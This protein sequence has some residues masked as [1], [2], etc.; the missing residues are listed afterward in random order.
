MKHRPVFIVISICVVALSAALCLHRWQ[1]P[2]GQKIGALQ[3]VT[4]ALRHYAIDHGGWFPTNSEAPLHALQAIYPSYIEQPGYLAGLSGDVQETTK[5][6]K[7]GR[8]LNPM[9]SS[10]VYW[11]GFKEDDCSDA[12]V[13]VSGGDRMADPASDSKLVA[14]IWE[15][16]TGI[17][18]NGKR[19]DGHAVGFSDGSCKQISEV[20]W[21]A[22]L[23]MQQK[24]RQAV[25]AQ[26]QR[27]AAR[28]REQ[29]LGS[30]GQ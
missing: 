15:R 9:I 11:P 21:P 3:L 22:F 19:G 5:A 8:S 7:T 12:R 6:L 23:D 17:L 18:S 10:W 26:R 29:P 1:Y 28:S 25:L 30:S 13:E 14:I 27:A 4:L 20:D 24:L 16:S 2:Y